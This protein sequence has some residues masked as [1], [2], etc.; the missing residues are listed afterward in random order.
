MPHAASGRLQLVLKPIR[1]HRKLKS[2]N[3]AR[4]KWS[5]ATFLISRYKF[6]KRRSFNAARGKW[7]VATKEVS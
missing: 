2:F 5:V 7:S 3:A 4:G 6:P 1:R